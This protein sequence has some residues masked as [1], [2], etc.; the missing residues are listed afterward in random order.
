MQ[1]EISGVRFFCARRGLK[2]EFKKLDDQGGIDPRFMFMMQII[3]Q[4][5]NKKNRN[6]NKL[7]IAISDSVRL[8]GNCDF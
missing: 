4:P 2:E 8:I 7:E 1:S 3:W 5:G 6:I